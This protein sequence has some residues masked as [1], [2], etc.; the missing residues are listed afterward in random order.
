MCP[1][2]KDILLN[3]FLS[4]AKDEDH[5]IRASSLSNLAEVC[6]VLGYK[7][8]TIVTEVII[9]KTLLT[10]STTLYLFYFRF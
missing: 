8:G 3:T 7:L 2:Y 1:K 9:R 4:G 6:E 5:L 10:C